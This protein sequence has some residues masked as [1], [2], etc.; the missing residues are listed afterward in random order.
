MCVSDT[1]YAG[2]YFVDIESV[3]TM[4]SVHCKTWEGRN[5]QNIKTAFHNVGT[6]VRA[7]S[8]CLQKRTLDNC[9]LICSAA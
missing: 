8:A 4:S 5:T 3:S 7:V 9:F 6:A 2:K 1:A